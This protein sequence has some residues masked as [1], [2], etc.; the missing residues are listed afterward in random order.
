MVLVQSKTGKAMRIH[1]ERMVSWYGRPQL[2]PVYIEDII[3]NFYLSKEG[4]VN[5]NQHCEQFS[6]V[7][8][9]VRESSALVSPTHRAN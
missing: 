7:G 3:F 9:R 8:K 6:A 4:E 2:I 1:F 5:G